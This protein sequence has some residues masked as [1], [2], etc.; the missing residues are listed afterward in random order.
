MEVK[1]E[2]CDTVVSFV[3]AGKIRAGHE[4]ILND[5]D[6]LH[7]AVRVTGTAVVGDDAVISFSSDNRRGEVT[8]SVGNR[9]VVLG[10]WS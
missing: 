4:I 10:P 6:G 1:V 5:W 2:R 7:V 3:E 8:T 9:F